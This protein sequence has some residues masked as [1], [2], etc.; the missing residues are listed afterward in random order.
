M[1]PRIL[2][3]AWIVLT[4]LLLLF[5]SQAFATRSRLSGV[6]DLS[7]VIEDESNMINL[8]D[9]AGNPAA[10]LE[11]EKGSILRGGVIWNAYQVDSL[12][13]YRPYNH[14]LVR[15]FEIN[16][17][18]FD[19]RGSFTLRRD[20][21]FAFGLAG[22]YFFRRTDSEWDSHELEHPNALLVLSRRVNRLTSVGASLRYTYYDFLFER[23]ESYYQGG[24]IEFNQETIKG[25]RGEIGLTRR[26]SSSAVFGASMGYERSQ[27]TW[28]YQDVRGYAEGSSG[29]QSAHG[30]DFLPRA[31][32]IAHT[33][34]LSCQTVLSL[35]EKIK[36]GAEGIVQLLDWEEYGDRETRLRLR[37][38]GLY[39]PVPLIRLGAFFADGTSFA[40][41]GDPIYS[42]FSSL[43][44]EIFDRELGGGMAFRFG[45]RLLTGVEYHYRDQPRPWHETYPWDIETHSVNIGVE[46]RLSEGLFARGGHI[47]STIRPKSEGD[48]GKDGWENAYTLGLGF[49][50]LE[51][52]F[53]L[54]FSF[55]YALKKYR[56][57]YGDLDLDSRSY[58]FSASVRKRFWD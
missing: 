33:G 23:V 52:D 44:E 51:S 1:R 48:G 11:D 58:V 13:Y 15:K 47:N 21:N 5:C 7:I 25:L 32:D 37:L 14:L 26:L 2:F 42:Y 36:L 46:G 40:E 9:F 55:R 16:G 49:E 27:I 39:D 24:L 54:E 17:D 10:L 41:Y 6:G 4:I 20:G 53:I 57:W 34:W 19:S 8:W 38:R 43:R 35:E 45:D 29:P 31:D 50:P 22:D 56:N 18:V 3:S 12:P 30:A 28:D